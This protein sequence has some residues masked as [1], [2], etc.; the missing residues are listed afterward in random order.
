VPAEAECGS[1]ADRD[2]IGAVRQVLARAHQQTAGSDAQCDL[3]AQA[4]RLVS[5]SWPFED[6]LGQA[7]LEC[8]R[9]LAV[10][11]SRLVERCRQDDS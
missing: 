1:T 11:R 3:V 6:G 10:S 8:A 9:S 5:D 2:R 7:V 4:A